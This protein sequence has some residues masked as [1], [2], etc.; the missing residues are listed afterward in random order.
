MF[1]PRSPLGLVSDAARRASD[2]VNLALLADREGNVGRWI[3]L[4]L[5]DGGSDGVVYDR[6]EHAA[7]AQLHYQLCMY[8]RIPPGGMPPREAEG[9]LAYHRAVYDAGHRP[10]YLD[11]YVPIIPIGGF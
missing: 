2:A 6:V 1:E 8:V 3:A 4:R 5:S 10:P 9:A 11:G 7:N